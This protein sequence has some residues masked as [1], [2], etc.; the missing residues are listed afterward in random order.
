MPHEELGTKRIEC[1]IGHL[2]DGGNVDR[3]IVRAEMIAVNRYGKEREQQQS[4][5]GIVTAD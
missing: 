2:L 1:G 4:D 5:G 3:P